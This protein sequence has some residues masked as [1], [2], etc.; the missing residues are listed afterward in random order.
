MFRLDTG[1][2]TYS[3]PA[4]L[5][6]N[7]LPPVGMPGGFMTLSA[8][9][10]TAGTAIVWATISAAGDA[11]HG[12]VP[13]TFR[14]FNAETLAPLWDSTGAGNDMGNLAKYNP[15][16]VAKGSVYVPSFSNTISVYRNMTVMTPLPR[17][18]WVATASN[19]NSSAPLALDNSTTTRYTSGAA[20]TNGMWFQV[21]MATAQTFNQINMSSAGSTNDYARGYQV[22][23]SNTN[24]DWA[25]TSPVASGTGTAASITVQFATRTARY[26]R[27]VQTGAATS[28][29]SI[30]ELNVY[31]GAPPR[32]RRPRRA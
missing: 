26:L 3:V 9:G 20:M 2:Q 4:A 18:G 22:L 6:G 19:G 24:T 11:N 16:L 31:G 12:T 21:D 25:T 30:A 14:A 29:W 23:V 5:V 10:S 27:I 8:N 7:V 28:W 13:G 1:T 15:P 17:T 32:L